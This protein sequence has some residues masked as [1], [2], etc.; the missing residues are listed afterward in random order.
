FPHIVEYGSGAG[1]MYACKLRVSKTYLAQRRTVHIYKID[2]TIGQ[3]G[4]LQYAHDH[5]RSI[6]L[7]ISGLPYHY[8]TAHGGGSR[9]VT[10]DSSKIKR[11]DRQ[12]ETFERAIFHPVMDS[13]G[14]DRLLP[15]NFTE[16][17]N[18]E[19]KKVDQFTSTVDFCLVG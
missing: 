6:D 17:M 19:P 1:K 4:F 10:T 16:E 9:K 12:H 11:S 7:C 13:G 14:T 18:I 5:L 8:I 3:S 2:H 15:V